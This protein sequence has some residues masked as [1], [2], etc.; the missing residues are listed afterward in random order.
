MRFN[1][2]YHEEVCK[3][4]FVDGFDKKANHGLWKLNQKLTMEEWGAVKEY[5][6]FYEKGDKFLCNVKYFGWATVNP[7]KVMKIIYDM[8]N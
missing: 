7:V 4:M 8:R 5:F 2:N 6:T 1:L 3:L